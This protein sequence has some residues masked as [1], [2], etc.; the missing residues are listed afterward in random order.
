MKNKRD[1]LDVDFIGT[2]PS[3][4]TKEE[5]K[6]ISD[7]IRSQKAKMRKKKSKDKVDL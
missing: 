7:Y 6:K 2:Q 1:E 5:E 4:L 3:K